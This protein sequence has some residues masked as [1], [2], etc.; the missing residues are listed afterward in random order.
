VLKGVY[1]SF[2]M[3]FVEQGW[4][5]TAKRGCREMYDNITN[6]LRLDEEDENV[7]LNARVSKITRPRGEPGNGKVTVQFRVGDGPV[8]HL[9]GDYLV[10]AIPPTLENLNKIGLKLADEEKDLFQ[11]MEVSPGYFGAKFENVSV[12][13]TSLTNTNL[14]DPLGQIDPDI[15][16]VPFFQCRFGNA[17]ACNGFVI[18]SSDTNLTDAAD[19]IT[20]QLQLMTLLDQPVSMTLTDLVEHENYFPHIPVEVTQAKPDYYGQINARQGMLKTLYIGAGPTYAGGTVVIE[21]AN[22]LVQE[23]LPADGRRLQ[24][25]PPATKLDLKKIVI[26]PMW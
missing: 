13:F 7:Y 2:L 18:S 4:M 26:P 23:F 1:G 21:H 9:V 22:R 8:R 24:T 6:Y 19:R 11:H 10:I 5:F 12:N 3:T 15:T 20:H 16:P 14:Q 25:A 17:S